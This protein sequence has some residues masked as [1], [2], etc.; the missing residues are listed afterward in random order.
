M[1]AINNNVLTSGF[2]LV[3]G[4]AAGA[5]MTPLGAGMLSQLA[6]SKDSILPAQ[7]SGITAPIAFPGP[8]PAP[9]PGNPGSGSWGS[10][11][12]TCG[13]GSGSCGSGSGSWGSG[14]GAG[15]GSSGFYSVINGFINQLQNMLSSLGQQLGLGGGSGQSGPQ[16]QTFFSSATSSSV[17]DP[18][19][20]FNGTTGAGNNESAKWDNMQSHADL[21][22]SDSFNGGYQ[23]S[24]TATAP[25]SNGI[26]MNASAQVALGGG[27]TQITMNA[28]GSYAVSSNGQNVALQQGQG[29]ML[30]DGE[31]VTL[32]A[33]KSL[34]VSDRDASG[35][36]LSTT[37]KANGNGGV[38]VSNTANNVDLGGYLVSQSDAG[39]G[40]APPPY[41]RGVAL[42]QPQ[43]SPV[44]YAW[45]APGADAGTENFPLLG[46]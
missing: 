24:T 6:G 38:D 7:P 17:G 20:A 12:G 19:D 27:S 35:G 26:T 16:A 11:S 34:T 8:E 30:G 25:G 4:G 45:E 1:S 37:L 3:P 28:D 14:S 10:G 22:S 46:A 13:P 21:L 44:S 31:S 32:N 15:A 23:V 41:Q 43:T 39:A 36:S 2:P 40:Y 33:D 29:V 5:A 18:H 42:P 9:G